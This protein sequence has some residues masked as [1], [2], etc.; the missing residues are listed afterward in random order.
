MPTLLSTLSPLLH[1]LYHYCHPLSYH[2][3]HYHI[4]YGGGERVY[5]RHSTI[6]LKLRPVVAARPC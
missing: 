2:H 6:S 3:I 5:L 4:E 1:T